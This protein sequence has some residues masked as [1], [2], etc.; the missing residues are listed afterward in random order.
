MHTP[1][2]HHREVGSQGTYN[3]FHYSAKWLHVV[4][5]AL[6]IKRLWTKISAQI[7]QLGIQSKPHFQLHIGSKRCLIS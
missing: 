7:S 6:A 3:G 4:K 2:G 5:D 1:S